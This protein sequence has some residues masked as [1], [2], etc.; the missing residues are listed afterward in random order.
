MSPVAWRR[1][2]FLQF[3]W[4]WEVESDVPLV[5]FMYLVF[6]RMPGESYRGQLR[7]LLLCLFDVFRVLM[8]SSVCWFLG[9]SHKAGKKGDTSFW[10]VT[11]N[12]LY[13][14]EIWRETAISV[15]LIIMI[16]AE[17]QVW[18]MVILS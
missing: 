9:G 12:I 4:L 5:E 18:V 16:L 14:T 10:R 13:K 1:S 3:H 2:S 8:N 17:L 15:H 11:P 6:T 7:S